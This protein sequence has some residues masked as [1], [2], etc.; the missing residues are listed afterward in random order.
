MGVIKADAPVIADSKTAKSLTEI[1]RRYTKYYNKKALRVSGHPLTF[2]QLFEIRPQVSLQ[3][4]DSKKPAIYLTTSGMLDHSNAPKHLLKM[5]DN[6]DNLLAIVGWQSPES[7]GRK[8]QD[9]HKKVN[10]SITD[11]D[12][13]GQ[14]KVT[15]YQRDVKIRVKSYSSFSSHA[16]GCYILKWL[17]NLKKT[18]GVFVVHGDKEN[19]IALSR[20]INRRLGFYAKAPTMSEKIQINNQH[21]LLD[22]KA[23][24]KDALCDGLGD[25]LKIDSLSDQ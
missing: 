9:G 8:L 2:D 14:K 17:S 23:Y 4:H 3:Y 1:Y 22:N 7:L 16:D 20:E 5:I 18:R 21:K 13:T 24:G 12:E 25:N 11:Y 15:N 10:I 19:A 6:P